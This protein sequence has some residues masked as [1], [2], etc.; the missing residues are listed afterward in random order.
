MGARNRSARRLLPGLA[1]LAAVAGLAWIALAPKPVAVEGAPAVRGPLEVTVD[2][3]AEVRVHDRYVVAAPVAGKLVRVALHDGDAVKAGDIVATLEPAPLDARAREEAVARLDA[4]RALVRE[5]EQNVAHAAADLE[6]AKRERARVE[7]L[8]AER[9]VSPEAAEKVH[10]AEATAIAALAAARA[11]VAA[12]ASEAR[13]AAAA[14]LA[15]PSAEGRSGRL[16]NL[17][18]PVSGRVFRVLEKSERTVSA[19]TSVMTIG[20]P[21]RFEIVADVLSTDAVKIKPGAPVRLEEWGGDRPLEARVRLVEPYAFTKI[22]ALGVEEQR[23]NVVMDPVD[24]LGPLGDGYRV[25]ARI[26]VWSADPV[27]KV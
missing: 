11:R 13:V 22:S 7:K 9:F 2:Q 1:L 16:V 6:Q 19:G 23:V 18:A 27:L 17:V 10:T 3:E 12:S 26:I 5:A 25:E 20:D 4:A 21:A 24:P 15:L 8:V 14:L